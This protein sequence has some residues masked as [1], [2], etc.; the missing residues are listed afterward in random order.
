MRRDCVGLVRS[1]AFWWLRVEDGGDARREVGGW[2]E[3][4][5]TSRSRTVARV[6]SVGDVLRKWWRRNS[7][8]GR[9]GGET[10]R[11]RAGVE[12]GGVTGDGVT[13]KLVAPRQQQ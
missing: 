1:Q 12:A 2:L 5:H 6:H 7:K 3:R 4:G 11:R 13:S 10:V 8:F 9:G